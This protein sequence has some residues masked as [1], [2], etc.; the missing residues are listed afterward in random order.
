MGLPVQAHG[1]QHRPAVGAAAFRHPRPTRVREPVEER[2]A[3]E[4]ARHAGV[5]RQELV[6]RLRAGHGHPS[7]RNSAGTVGD[8][9]QTATV[10]FQRE[11]VINPLRRPPGVHRRPAGDGSMRPLTFTPPSR[12]AP[13]AP[14]A[15]WAP[16]SAP[17][18]RTSTRCR[19]ERST[20]RWPTSTRW[21]C[22]RASSRPS[23]TARRRASSS[24]PSA[25]IHLLRNRR[26]ERR[27]HPPH[28]R[29]RLEQPGEGPEVYSKLKEAPR[30]EI[31]IE[32][33]GAP[34]RKTYN[35]R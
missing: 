10:T 15:A 6:L 30:I 13:A 2:P 7:A 21:P 28:Q 14:T 23:R 19:A 3:R 8:P 12:A 11:R 24:S 25:R 31:E 22:R 32:R 20:R 16:A 9:T 5:P 4:A 27:R 17:S 26:A 34:I 29:V 35:V 18:A 33:N 1:H